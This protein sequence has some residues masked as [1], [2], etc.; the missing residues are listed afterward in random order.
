VR[1][2]EWQRRH[3]TP[4]RRIHAA[5]PVRR[6]AVGD[7]EPAS[8]GRPPGRAAATG[9][10]HDG[11]DSPGRRWSRGDAPGAAPSSAWLRASPGP[12]SWVALAAHARSQEASGP[13]LS[14]SARRDGAQAAG[15]APGAAGGGGL[16]SGPAAAAASRDQAPPPHA[17][18][19]MA[20]TESS[21]EPHGNLRA[22]S[23]DAEQ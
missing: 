15:R 20:R 9:R 23:A 13:R 5:R 7:R 4:P 16:A 3:T 8:G 18:E 21:G 11:A 22:R 6:S 14:A 12:P 19:A 10:L 2:V 1:S 17:A